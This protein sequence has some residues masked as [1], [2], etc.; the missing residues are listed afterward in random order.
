MRHY[1]AIMAGCDQF[2]GNNE[3]GP[4]LEAFTIMKERHGKEWTDVRIRKSAERLLLNMFRLGLFEM[5]YLDVSSTIETV[6]CKEYN[7]EGYLYPN[8]YYFNK[9]STPYE[10]IDKMI[11]EFQL[12]LK[13]AENEAGCTVS[14]NDIENLIVKASLIEISAS[15]YVFLKA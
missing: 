2:G 15:G 12:A 7:L 11:E 3:K 4:V 6:A 14:E 10:V 8:T 1:L 13:E 5:P 9:K